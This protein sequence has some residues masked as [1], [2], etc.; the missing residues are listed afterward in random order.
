MIEKTMD[1]FFEKD[2]DSVIKAS[3]KEKRSVLY[4]AVFF[5]ILTVVFF[6]MFM[7]QL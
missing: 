6:I 7:K 2:T 5:G 3:E 4:T 1:N